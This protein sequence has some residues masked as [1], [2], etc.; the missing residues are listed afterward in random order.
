M[1]PR[2]WDLRDLGMALNLRQ[3]YTCTRL[4]FSSNSG[5]IYQGIEN[6]IYDFMIRYNIKI[7]G[8]KQMIVSSV[9][10]SSSTRTEILPEMLQ[11]VKMRCSV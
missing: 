10:N 11:V 1:F 7:L 2:E 5:N 3:S 9:V 8:V 4:A 6:H